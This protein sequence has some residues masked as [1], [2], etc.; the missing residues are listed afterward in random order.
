MNKN[1]LMSLAFVAAVLFLGG[2]H[3]DGYVSLRDSVG[4]G[5]AA[6]IPYSQYF[7]DYSPGYPYVYP[8]P[9][10]YYPYPYP[11]PPSLPVSPEPG[12]H[13]RSSNSSGDIFS[14]GYRIP[15]LQDPMRNLS[16]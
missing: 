13:F 10:Y 16:S 12:R 4:Y 3:N 14:L 15:I 11:Y 2:C 7:Y 6:T 1:R 8:Y 9:P 5:E